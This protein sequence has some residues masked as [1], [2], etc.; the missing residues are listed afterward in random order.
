MIK[1]SFTFSLLIETPPSFNILLASPFELK[2]FVLSVRKSTIFIP[3]VTSVRDTSHLGTP[4]K[5][6]SNTSSERLFNV[7]V[8]PFP[9]KI[10][11]ASK[12]VL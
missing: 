5:T 12:A 4:S 6:E 11:D 10:V 7:S 3:S 8:V 9:N 2:M 1:V